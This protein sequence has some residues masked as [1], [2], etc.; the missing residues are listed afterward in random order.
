[1]AFSKLLKLAQDSF[2][3]QHITKGEQGVKYDKGINV[4]NVRITPEKVLNERS[5][6]NVTTGG[7]AIYHFENH[8]TDVQEFKI[9]SRVVINNQDY[10]IQSITKPNIQND[11]KYTKIGVF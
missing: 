4:S 10:T 9:G 1:M 3:Y 8:S 2:E 6:Y 5:G 11:Y 7:F